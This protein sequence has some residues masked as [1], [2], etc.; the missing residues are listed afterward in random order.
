MEKKIKRTRDGI[1][2]RS[3][4]VLKIFEDPLTPENIATCIEYDERSVKKSLSKIYKCLNRKDKLLRKENRNGEYFYKLTQKGNKLSILELYNTYKKNIPVSN[5]VKSTISKSKSNIP[6]ETNKLGIK[7]NEGKPEKNRTKLVLY[8]L[9]LFNRKMS[10]YD[11]YN[12]L[13]K[14]IND[15]VKTS[16][17]LGKLYKSLNKYGFMKREKPGSLYIY[18]IT[19]EGRQRSFDELY[20]IIYEYCKQNPNIKEMEKRLGLVDVDNITQEQE[21]LSLFENDNKV[22][23]N[24]TIT[25]SDSLP[26]ESIGEKIDSIIYYI[27]K[28]HDMG[29]ITISFNIPLS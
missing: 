15:G 28:N 7:N 25:E 5:T 11:V 29:D 8:S 12:L 18:Y 20:S 1:P 9:Y 22:N 23:K 16:A 2:F 19:D 4:N 13:F 14:D 21:Q 17:I 24:I 10:C 26:Q 27:K 3:L 6:P